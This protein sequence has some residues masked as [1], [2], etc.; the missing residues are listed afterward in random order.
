MK[1]KIHAA[2]KDGIRFG[3]TTRRST[4]NSLAPRLR[5]I[6]SI[7]TSSELTATDITTI[8]TAIGGNAS[9]ALLWYSLL[10]QRDPM[11]VTNARFQSGWS[12]L[13]QVL[14]QPRMTAIA[15]ALNITV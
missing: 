15:T 7:W 6:C 11:V 9:L 3:K 4:V 5:A 1:A 10:A 2:T 14:G 13:V 8:Q 12:A